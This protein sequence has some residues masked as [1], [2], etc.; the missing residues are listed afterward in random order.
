MF[1]LQYDVSVVLYKTQLSDNT[2]AC[3]LLKCLHQDQT[4]VTATPSDPTRTHPFTRH[5]KVCGTRK[6]KRNTAGSRFATVR[7]TIH[8]YDI[9]LRGTGRYAARARGKEIQQGLV[10]RLFVLRRFT[11]TT[12]IYV[13]LDG[14]RH[15]QEEK[16]YSRVSFCDGS[17]YDDSLLRHPFTCHW[18]AWGTRKRERNTAGSRFCDGSFYDDSLLRHLSSRTEYTR[19]VVRHCRNS[20]VLSVLSALLAL[21]RCACVYVYS[22]LVRFF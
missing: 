10:L 8:F 3:Y 14:M 20:S 21:F 19:L 6:G 5:W 15:A 12:P 16:K 7:F 18:T 13:P 4:T 1:T 17:F 9:H 2:P 11:F 22:I